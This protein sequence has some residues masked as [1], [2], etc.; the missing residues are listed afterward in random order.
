MSESNLEVF[1]AEVQPQLGN[2]YRAAFRLAGNRSD[3]EDL[4]QE[5]CLRAWQKVP[6]GS[7]PEHAG[8]WLFRV[9][10]HLF[11]DGTRRD[12][13]G[14]VL[15]KSTDDESTPEPASP[16]PGP[17]A[18]AERDDAEF[19]LDQAW[20]KLERSQRVLLAL[21]AEGYGLG[22]IEQI[23]GISHTVLRARLHRARRSFSRH[24]QSAKNPVELPTQLASNK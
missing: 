22:E 4:V 7:D 8:R 3:A 18:L 13:N 14:P 2:L 16:G 1:K 10:Y 23:T 19:A 24:L 17:D 11:I 9:L 6:S 21:R 5:T 20:M 12:R 15:W